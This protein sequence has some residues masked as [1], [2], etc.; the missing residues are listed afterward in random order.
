M[1]PTQKVL[2]GH[3][4]VKVIGEGCHPASLSFEL[5]IPSFRLRRLALRVAKR[6]YSLSK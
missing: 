5:R 3:A 6:S 4:A 2:N 1:K